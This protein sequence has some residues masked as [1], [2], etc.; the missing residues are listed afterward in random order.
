[1][2][3]DK[4]MQTNDQA[5]N[6]NGLELKNSW[7][8]LDEGLFLAGIKG[9]PP[10]WKW[11]D[12]I[13]DFVGFKNFVKKRPFDGEKRYF[14]DFVRGNWTKTIEYAVQSFISTSGT[15]THSVNGQGSLFCCTD[16]TENDPN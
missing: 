2:S 10:I 8:Q 14:W 1:M 9:S 4:K 5:E 6:S 7:S 12:K 3:D 11:F 13:A 15:H 16:I